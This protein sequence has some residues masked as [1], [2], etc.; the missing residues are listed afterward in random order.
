M[1][2]RIDA[3]ALS[4]NPKY[5]ANAALTRKM[6]EEAA[7]LPAQAA[8]LATFAARKRAEGRAEDARKA[9]GSGG[10]GAGGE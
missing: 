3:W 4:F 1:L 5:A 8:A 7:C 2:E 9:A 10:T 6:Q